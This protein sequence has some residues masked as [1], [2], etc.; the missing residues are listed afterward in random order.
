MLLKIFSIGQKYQY[1]GKK[2]EA[3]KAWPKPKSISH[4]QVFLEFANFYQRFI[5]SFSKIAIPLTSMLKTSIAGTRIL[6]KTAHNFTFLIFKVK[7]A[8]LRLKQAFTKTSILYY[9]APQYSIQIKT[10]ASGYAIDGILSQLILEFDQWHLVVF[11]TWKMILTETRYK[12]YNKELLAIVKAF[13]SWQH[14]LKGCKF[15]ILIFTNHHN[16]NSFMDTKNMSS[17]QV[18]QI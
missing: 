15:K 10:D 6:P 12:T 8:F 4:I 7:L 17:K 1:R 11:F 3:V 18:C 2:I 5:Q 13:K 16:L 14:Y 9:F